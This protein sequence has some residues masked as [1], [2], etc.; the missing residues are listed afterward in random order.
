[1]TNNISYDK[2]WAEINSLFTSNHRK[3]T[4]M[5]NRKEIWLVTECSNQQEFEYHMTELGL[6]S[7]FLT[8]EPVII[9]DL[10]GKPGVPVGSV[11]EELSEKLEA[12]IL[13]KGGNGAWVIDFVKTHNYNGHW[14]CDKMDV[15]LLPFRC[16]RVQKV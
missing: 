11:D 10:E 15:V 7:E 6:K 16:T 12:T 14:D 5:K 8:K 4:V 9:T 13:E 2:I 1:L 3:E